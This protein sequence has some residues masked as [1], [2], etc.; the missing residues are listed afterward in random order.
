MKNRSNFYC[1]EKEKPSNFDK[2]RKPTSVR[3]KALFF[4]VRGSFAVKEKHVSCREEAC[5]LPLLCS[6]L[7]SFVSSHLSIIIICSSCFCS[8]D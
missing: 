4:S 1:I 7:L 3:Q 5:L 2:R 8:G 6:A